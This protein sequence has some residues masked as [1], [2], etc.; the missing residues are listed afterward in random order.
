MEWTHPVDAFLSQVFSPD[1]SV[2]YRAMASLALLFVNMHLPAFR[3]H[4]AAASTKAGR[5]A[6]LPFFLSKVERVQIMKEVRTL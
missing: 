5:S 6:C 3:P 2:V 1:N 4:A